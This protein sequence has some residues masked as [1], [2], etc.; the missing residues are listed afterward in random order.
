MLYSPST[1]VASSAD[2]VRRAPAS[3]WCTRECQKIPHVQP[4]RIQISQKIPHVQP[5]KNRYGCESELERPADLSAQTSAPREKCERLERP[6][7][8][9]LAKPVE[10]LTSMLLY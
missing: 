4:K 8:K 1:R 2:L 3:T 6:A 10:S 9:A 7:G 5:K